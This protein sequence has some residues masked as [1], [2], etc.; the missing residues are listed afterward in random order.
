[1][2]NNNFFVHPTAEVSA[3]SKIGEGTKVWNF[4]QIREDTKIGKNCIIS[5]GKSY[6]CL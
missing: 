2:S 1:M 4:A 3:D 5:K 6:I